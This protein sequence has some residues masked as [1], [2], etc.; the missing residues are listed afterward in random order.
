[1]TPEREEQIRQEAE[2]EYPRVIVTTALE[3]ELGS[4][5]EAFN[6]ARREAYI[7]GAHSRQREIEELK[8]YLNHMIKINVFNMAWDEATPEWKEHHKVSEG[9]TF[10]EWFNRVMV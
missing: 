4:L 6:Q 2:R 5:A 10:I 3:R 1:M 8:S 9:E 7:A